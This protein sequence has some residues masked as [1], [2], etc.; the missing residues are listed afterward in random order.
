MHGA[1]PNPCCKVTQ[2]LCFALL[3]RELDLTYFYA[4]RM[5][6][7]GDHSP[8][9][10]LDFFN[11]PTGFHLQILPVIAGRWGQCS[12]TC[13]HLKQVAGPSEQSGGD[14]LEKRPLQNKYSLL[15]SSPRG[16]D[17]WFADSES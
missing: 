11:W 8:A 15:S 7:V 10:F 16:C 13:L 2:T 5:T 1:E 12:L 14:L 9:H 4:L 6:P 17:C 3:W